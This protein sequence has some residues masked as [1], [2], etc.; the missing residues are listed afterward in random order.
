MIGT[1]AANH[2]ARDSNLQ[3]IVDRLEQD[4]LQPPIELT[5]T[6][7]SE[8]L[9][10]DRGL[11]LPNAVIYDIAR[12]APVDASGLEVTTGL[13]KW[14]FEAVGDAILALMDG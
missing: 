14:Q 6:D 7:L 2:I 3:D 11:L 13:R 8:E 4:I 5:A 1:L 10:I 12:R 9:G